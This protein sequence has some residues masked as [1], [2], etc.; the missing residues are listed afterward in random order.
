M[1]CF[2]CGRPVKKLNSHPVRCDVH[3]RHRFCPTCIPDMEKAGI[4]RFAVSVMM[5]SVAP[6][7][8]T[9]CPSK[10]LLLSSRLMS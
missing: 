8:Q 6:S 5:H 9:L 3:K 4:L 2:I 10:E 1:V 7:Y